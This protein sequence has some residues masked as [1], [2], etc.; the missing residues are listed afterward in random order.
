MIAKNH[1]DLQYLIPQNFVGLR[2]RTKV[3]LIFTNTFKKNKN[4]FFRV[5]K[6]LLALPRLRIRRTAAFR[7]YYIPRTSFQNWQTLI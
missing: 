4:L 3:K 2:E 5:K 1:P 7:R 6:K